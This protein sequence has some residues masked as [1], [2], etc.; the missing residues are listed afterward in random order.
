MLQFRCIWKS[1]CCFECSIFIR[2]LNDLYEKCFPLC[3]K[4]YHKKK[5]KHWFDRDLAIL[6]KLKLTKFNFRISG[7][8]SCESYIE[9]HNSYSSI[10]KICKL[11]YFRDQFNNCFGDIME[12]W[13]NI[14]V[15]IGSRKMTCITEIKQKDLVINDQLII[16]NLF[17]AYFSS[18]RIDLINICPYI[19]K[20]S[21]VMC[22]G[23]PRKFVWTFTKWL[24]GS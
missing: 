6:A 5:F 7:I 11:N 13:R 19:S 20:L 22:G 12:T 24:W 4:V 17:S 16:S 8:L 18:I 15:L 9:F 1:K 3:T 2:S 14:N 10:I 21:Y 23:T